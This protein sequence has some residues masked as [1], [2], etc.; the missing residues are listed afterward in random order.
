MSGAFGA[1]GG[2]LSAIAINPAS[3]AIINNGHFS[4]SFGSDNKSGDVNILNSSRSFEKDN[5]TLNQ[6]GGM[7][8]FENLD[9]GEKWKKI[10]LGI[11]YNQSKNHFNEF[12][13]YNISN[14]NSIDSYFLNN[15]NGL[16]INE[17]SA[18]EDESISDA[19]I[20]IGNVF[21]Y[22]HQ[23]AFLGYESFIIDPNPDAENTYISNVP[24][25]TFNQ[26][27]ISISRGYNGKLSFNAGF[28]YNQNIYFGVNLN[29]HFVDYDNYTIFNE[30]NSNG[31]SG[32]F[33]VDGIYFE[34]RLSAFGEGFSAQIGMISKLND[35]LRLGFVYDS[36]TWY[37]ISE[38]TSQYLETSII[39][40]DNNV[41][42]LVTNPNAVN[43]YED[44]TLRTPSK[45][46]ASTALV[47]KNFGLVSFDYSRRDYSSI[48]FK[49]EN[50][51]HFSNINQEIKLKLKDV[52]TFRFGA[53]ILADRF[54]FRGGYM[55]ENS[56]Y[57]SNII[58]EYEN[59]DDS[60]KGFSLGLGYKLNNTMIDLSFV[61]INSSKY[62]RLY[63]TGLTDQVNVNAK[64][65]TITFSVST[66][67]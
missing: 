14:N 43:I 36:P 31:E 66:I 32:E 1:L 49:P 46:T 25:G 23:Q 13:V 6:I 30:N 65:K 50:D 40:S 7:I 61:K 51:S 24:S 11:V 47:F 41:I 57:D 35:V 4:I 2:D 52:N 26:D 12:S 64:N 45:I 29:S 37:T 18:F 19:Y 3:S 60:V 56:P 33:R 5:F 17:I 20:D 27:F 28:Q 8:N 67:F 63:E 58:S 42:L 34:N 62:K 48:K 21:G 39:D 10:S 38:E 59:T 54:S 44:Y 55:F 22:A 16:P 9:S 53:E 15:A